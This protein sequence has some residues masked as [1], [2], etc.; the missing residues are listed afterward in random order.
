MQD[1]PQ[2]PTGCFY[3]YTFV[4]VKTTSTVWIHE[5][6]ALALH[7]SQF[8][9]TVWVR[10]KQQHLE[11]CTVYAQLKWQDWP[12][13]GRNS[14][15]PLWA[16]HS[17]Q[18]ACCTVRPYLGPLCKTFP[19]SRGALSR[20]PTHGRVSARKAPWEPERTILLGNRM[21]IARL[22]TVTVSNVKACRYCEYTW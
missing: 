18:R 20:W 19:A 8:T 2:G 5:S 1:G 14:C 21:Q 10:I 22:S 3:T 12:Q 7:H 13:C 17:A 9:R 4:R 16:P 6:W 15:N 11:N